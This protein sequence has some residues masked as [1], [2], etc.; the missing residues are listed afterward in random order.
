MREEIWR[1]HAVF[2]D[3][4]SVSD[5]YL[6]HYTSLQ[7]AESIASSQS[8]WA[9]PLSTLNDPRESKS[10]EFAWMRLYDTA[11]QDQGRGD[12]A[13][14]LEAL[15]AQRAALRI[16]CFTRDGDVE[17]TANLARADHRGYARSAMWAHYGGR[18]EGVCFVFDRAKLE[19][20]ASRLLTPSEAHSHWFD[21]EYIPGFD[22]ELLDAETVDLVDP[23]ARDRHHAELVIPSLR[24]K[25]KDWSYEAERRLLVDPWV[26]HDPCA[27]PLDG[28][29]A[30][31]VLGV[32]FKA[33][34]LSLIASIESTFALHDAV[35]KLVV[36]PNVLVPYPARGRDG[37]LHSWTDPETRM[38]DLIFEP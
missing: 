26:S 33:A 2:G 3:D 5:R 36:Y 21:V 28:V 8:L 32:D 35:A 24:R 38:R 17:S 12:E 23:T 4:M 37:L 25:N 19:E 6:Y 10:R 34:D 22:A 30:G 29:V 18:H 1:R 13:V 15:R 20:S 16:A 7:K 11:S 27:I 9:G 14:V 31:L